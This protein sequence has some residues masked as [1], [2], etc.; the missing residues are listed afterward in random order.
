MG[1]LHDGTFGT[2]MAIGPVLTAV[3]LAPTTVPVSIITSSATIIVSIAV[4]V[5]VAVTI[6]T[7][8]ST[9]STTV[10]PVAIM[11][12]ARVVIMVA[13]M[14]PVVIATVVAAVV[15]VVVV[16]IAPVPPMGIVTVMPVMPVV[17]E[18]DRDKGVD[19]SAI[20]VDK[21][22]VGSVIA[23]HRHGATRIPIPTVVDVIRVIDEA[24][25]TQTVGVATVPAS[26]DELIGA[27]PKTV[28]IIMLAT[29]G[30]DIDDIVALQEDHC[31]IGI[32]HDDHFRVVVLND[33]GLV[34]LRF[35]LNHNGLLTGLC[36]HHDGFVDGV[37]D[38]VEI[39]GVVLHEC[40]LD[41]DS[42]G[43][44]VVLIDNGLPVSGLLQDDRGRLRVRSILDDHAGR[45]RYV[46]RAVPI[47]RARACSNE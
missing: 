1:S 25:Q 24:G 47:D 34:G 4:T 27:I 32:L 3:A 42:L 40:I 39:L 41:N 29:V 30:I 45:L 10:V 23:D 37:V 7:A 13:T 38:D 21:A 35:L 46:D 43:A 6:A 44:G 15:A 20:P 28:V 11:M 19:P 12:I 22:T 31:G 26:H 8:T 14:A 9:T 16:A 17:A 33:D 2:G 18:V 5:T 36:L